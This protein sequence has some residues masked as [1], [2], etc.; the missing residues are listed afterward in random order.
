MADPDLLPNL[1]KTPELALDLTNPDSFKQHRDFVIGLS[2]GL[3]QVEQLAYQK[4]IEAGV[5]QIN[6]IYS[7]GGGTHNGVWM[8]FRKALLPASFSIADNQD[9]AYGVTLLID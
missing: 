2:L 6:Q 9:A 3:A 7:V 5:S 8:Q 4:L 1:P